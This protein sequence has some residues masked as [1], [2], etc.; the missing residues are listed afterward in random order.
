MTG[1]LFYKDGREEAVWVDCRSPTFQM[2]ER[3]EDGSARY[4]NFR[5]A[6]VLRING[7]RPAHA[8]EIYYRE[9]SP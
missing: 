2:V 9:I 6:S 7:T 4:V 5:I 8:G 1:R 3:A